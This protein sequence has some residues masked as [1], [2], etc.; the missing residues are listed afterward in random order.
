VA[1]AAL[2]EGIESLPTA[3]LDRAAMEIRLLAGDCPSFCV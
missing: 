1:R 3:G 2:R